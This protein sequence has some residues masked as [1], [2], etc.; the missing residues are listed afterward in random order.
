MIDVWLALCGLEGN[1]FECERMLDPS[2]TTLQ[3]KLTN[4]VLSEHSK[5][6]GAFSQAE[7]FIFDQ[8]GTIGFT[9]RLL[10]ER[11]DKYLTSQ[12]VIERE[13]GKMLDKKVKRKYLTF[14]AE[15]EN[16]DKL[17][18]ILSICQKLEPWKMEFCNIL[19]FDWKKYVLGGCFKSNLFCIKELHPSI[20]NWLKEKVISVDRNSKEFDTNSPDTILSNQNRRNA[21]FPVD[22]LPEKELALLIKCQD[23]VHNLPDKL[24]NITMQ[25]EMSPFSNVENSLTEIFTILDKSLW[26]TMTSQLKFNDFF[27]LL[28]DFVCC[29][30]SCKFTEFFNSL[31]TVVN[32][33]KRNLD[34]L[35]EHFDVNHLIILN[36]SWGEFDFCKRGEIFVLKEE[37]E[38]SKITI[39]I[40]NHFVNLYFANLLNNSFQKVFNLILSLKYSIF[41]NQIQIKEQ[42]TWNNEANFVTSLHNQL[43]SFLLEYFLSDVVAIELENFYQSVN[44]PSTVGHSSYCKAI[45][46]LSVR[47]QEG[48]FLDAS[49]ISERLLEIIHW[50]ANESLTM[51]DNFTVWK[52]MVKFLVTGMQNTAGGFGKMQFLGMF[53]QRIDFNFFFLR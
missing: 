14:L 8:L 16:D 38:S 21:N 53:L 35:L 7:Q 41:T 29:M 33:R 9:F 37:G 27:T 26:T 23:L 20:F 43:L 52:E 40:K 1:L 3:Y 48:L 49:F 24:I 28:K 19:E 47:L 13:L 17:D 22:F 45:G 18:G 44:C 32:V 30:D 51:E 6:S 31:K 12:N 4:L 50:K 11:I 2:C 5:L 36:E 39:S 34:W 46:N 15:C 42:P 25:F 10:S